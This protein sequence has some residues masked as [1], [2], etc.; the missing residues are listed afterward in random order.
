MR[1]L[2]F[3]FQVSGLI[4]LGLCSCSSPRPSP[5]PLAPSPV[6]VIRAVTGAQTAAARLAPH[7]TPEGKPALASLEETLRLAQDE[8]TR[9]TALVEQ[10]SIKRQQAE[11]AASYWQ[12]KQQKALRELWIWRGIAA[13]VLGSIAAWFALRMGLKAA[14]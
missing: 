3:R 12:G 10:E 1:R 4:L 7:V 11:I 6:G 5:S 8:V 2:L 14:L 9:Y 13:L